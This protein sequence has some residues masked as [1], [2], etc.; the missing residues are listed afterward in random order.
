MDVSASDYGTDY[1][2]KVVIS[3]DD[4]RV[5]FGNLAALIS[6]REPDICDEQS[7]DIAARVAGGRDNMPQLPQP[8]NEGVFVFLS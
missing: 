3:Y 6:H 2:T 1:G 4:V 8:E 7:R 5:S